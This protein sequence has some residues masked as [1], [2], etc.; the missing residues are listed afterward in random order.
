MGGDFSIAIETSCRIG[1]LALGKGDQLLTV[2][3]FDASRR[4]A[5][6]LLAR[7]EGL[8]ETAALKPADLGELYVSLGPGS[9]TALRVGVTVARTLAQF[10]AGLRCVAVGAA[11]VVAR[12]AESLDWEHLAVVMDA[13]EG[14]VHATLFARS[15]GGIVQTDEPVIARPSDFLASAPRPLLLTGEGLWHYDLAGAGIKQADDSLRLPSVE[16]VWRVG[17]R[18]ARQGRYTQPHRLN[19]IYTRLPKVLRE[20]DRGP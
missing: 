14:C 8:L 4:H 15:E 18:E 1:G 9:F 19:P 16:N 10:V 2:E 13:R 7:L 20:T 3:T 5:T 11:E 17:R 6:I 12:N